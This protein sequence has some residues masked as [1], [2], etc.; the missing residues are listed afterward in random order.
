M[1]ITISPIDGTRNDDTLI[2]SS[3]G[4]VISGRNGDDVITANYGHDEG[5]GGKGDDLINGNGGNDTLYGDA[6][7]SFA[8]LKD[9]VIAYDYPVTVT[10]QGEEAGYKNTFGWYKIDSESGQI[11][12]VEIIWENA[13][14]TG[15]GGDLVP[16]ETQEAL[17]VSAGDKIG[18]FIIA[19]GYS[20]NSSFFESAASDGGTYEFR[21]ASGNL[22]GIDD[23]NP[24]LYHIAEDGTVTL[25]QENDYH[26]AAFDENL[27]LNPDGILHTVGQLD[28]QNGVLELGFEDL[29]NGGD[30][31]FDDTVFSVDIGRANVEVLNAHSKYGASGFD[32]INGEIVVRSDLESDF[33]YLS[34]TAIGTNHWDI[35]HMTMTNSDDDLIFVT[36]IY[37][38]NGFNLLEDNGTISLFVASGNIPISLSNTDDAVNLPEIDGTLIS[39]TMAAGAMELSLATVT[40]GVAGAGS[41]IPSSSLAINDGMLRANISLSELD[42]SVGDKISWAGYA[43][44]HHNGLVA[45]DIFDSSK[46]YEIASFND[47]IGGQNGNDIIY[48]EKGSDVIDGGDGEDLIKGGSGSD[49]IEGGS[50]DDTLYGNSGDDY[51]DGGNSNDFVAGGSGADSLF[52]GDGH[53]RLEGHSGNDLLYGGS[54][55][56]TLIASSGNDTVD[57]GSGNDDVTAG[58]GDDYLIA[59]IGDDTLNGGSGVDTLSFENASSGINADLNSKSCEGMGNDDIISI[60]NLIGSYHDDF[61]YGNY[62]ENIIEGSEGKDR[63]YGRGGD[64]HISGGGGRDYLVGGSGED[65]LFGDD[66]ND[67]LKGYKGVDFLT[68]GAGSDKFVY[69][70]MAELGDFISDFNYEGDQDRIDIAAI[71]DNLGISDTSEVLDTYLQ[72]SDNGSGDTVIKLDQSGSGSNWDVV[73]V[74]LSDFDSLDLDISQFILE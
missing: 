17:D 58:S 34:P 11:K 53:D 62:L 51:I 69:K 43:N 67:V 30:M 66:G 63:L 14:Q 48:G 3:A 18:F 57:G 8:I 55:S 1:K 52:G 47:T 74:T 56:D 10:F 41:I 23:V 4:E 40:G 50:A 29:Y 45:L 65:S 37:D 32:V 22:A 70:S 35:S 6:S 5:W 73:M 33:N 72:Y 54:G 27:Q 68:G 21:D 19:N 36:S 46:A 44:S 24:N 31:D 61:L 2:G 13:S 16:G 49:I 26:S 20:I 64:D 60:E 7:P 15:S 25:I 42:L 59:D 39:I 28:A 38:A 9:V 71:F 12:N